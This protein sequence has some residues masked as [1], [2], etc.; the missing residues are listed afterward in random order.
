MATA[1][2]LTRSNLDALEKEQPA[3]EKP[4]VMVAKA[5]EETQDVEATFEEGEVVRPLTGGQLVDGTVPEYRQGK[6]PP[7]YIPKEE[8]E[9][10]AELYAGTKGDRWKHKEGWVDGHADPWSD[11]STW[12]GVTVTT[13]ADGNAHVTKL[14]L[15]NNNVSGPIPNTISKLRYLRELYL[16][17]NSISGGIPGEIGQCPFLRTLV[18]SSN[19]ITDYLPASLSMCTEL[20]H[21][22]LRTNSIIG[23]LPKGVCLGCTQLIT[24]NLASNHIAGTLPI[25]IDRLEHLEYFCVNNNRVTGNLPPGLGNM[26]NLEYFNVANNAMRGAIPAGIGNLPNLKVFSASDNQ[27][28]GRIPREIVKCRKLRD[29][30]FQNNEIAELA[31]TKV[32]MAAECNPKMKYFIGPDESDSSDSDPSDSEDEQDEDADD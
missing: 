18:L 9:F 10:L 13:E 31:E 29:F 28:T 26:R 17:S 23:G 2:S 15:F 4:K 11:P 12:H 16:G 19:L 22:D 1:Q 3:V 14:R 20:R 8:R 6:K 7:Q 5:A 25:Q 32:W 30:R 21:L 27:F 24:I